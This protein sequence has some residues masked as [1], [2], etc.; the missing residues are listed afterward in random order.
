MRT[1]FEHSIGK[2]E[3]GS[4]PSVILLS[5]KALSLKNFYLVM[6]LALGS[7]LLSFSKK[8]LSLLDIVPDLDKDL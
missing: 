7:H 2:C 1:D 4:G 5:D 3:C 8:F 6:F